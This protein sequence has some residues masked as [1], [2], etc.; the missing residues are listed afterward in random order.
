M[1]GVS[2]TSDDKKAEHQTVW[3]SHNIRGKTREK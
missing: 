1:T 2:K 3:F